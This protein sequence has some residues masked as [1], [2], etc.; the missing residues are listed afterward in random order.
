M[1]VAGHSSGGG[2]W[3]STSPWKG[4]KEPWHPWQ[5]DDDDEG[6]EDPDDPAE[7]LDLRA[8]KACGAVGYIR[9]DGC[10]N[11]LCALAALSVCVR[12]CRLLLSCACC[13]ISFF[14]L[15]ASQ[16]CAL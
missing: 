10:V 11:K 4:G 6:D 15:V 2:G 5:N 13:C 9:K 14:S 8:C 7:Q 3:D 12:V 1:A 16:F